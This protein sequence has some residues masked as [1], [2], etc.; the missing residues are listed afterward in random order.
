MKTII[1][2]KLAIGEGMPKICVPIVGKTKADILGTAEK[3]CETPADL[4]EWRADWFEGVFD[5]EVVC[6]VLSELRDILGEI[7]LLFTF[8]TKAEGG[9]QEISNDEYE[10]LLVQV[11]Q[12][13]LVD[14]IDVE[15]YL[16]E[17][18]PCLISKLKENGVVIVGSNHDFT[19]TPEK[20]EIVKRLVYMKEVGA[21][22]PKIA[23][24]PKTEA[25]V[26]TLLTAT[27]E[28][29][30]LLKTPIITMAMGTLGEISR[31]SGEIYGSAITFGA[32]G[33]VSAPGQID[34]FKLKEILEKVH[35]EKAE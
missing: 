22:L 29:A 6:G 28:V 27:K 32:V 7:P 19:K 24:M 21:D 10:N 2:K 30:N 35:R 1:V 11:S 20:D 5:V 31:T 25:D 9:E 12:T 15:A 13:G 3:I 14:M 34:V 18:I 17:E 16:H 4:V 23:V 26:E 8:R 33:T